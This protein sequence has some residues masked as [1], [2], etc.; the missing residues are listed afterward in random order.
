MRKIF[1]LLLAICWMTAGFSQKFRDASEL[2]VV[3][4]PF[5]CES[6]PFHRV[7]S[8]RYPRLLSGIKYRYACPA[9]MAIAFK[10]NSNVIKARW[11]TSPRNVGANMT[12]NAQK[13]LDLYIKQKGKW[14]FAGIAIPKKENHEYTLVGN[15]MSG[16]KECLL[17]LPVYDVLKSLEIGVDET[18]FLQ[19]LEPPFKHRI[20][21]YGSSIVHGVGVSR[22]GMTYPAL[23]SR[24]TGM[25]FINM[26]ISGM[27]KME[28]E[29]A[30]MLAD[31]EADAYILD[32][33]PNP[34][35]DQIRER[36]VPFVKYLRERR[37]GKPII[38]IQTIR[39]ETVNFDTKKEDLETAKMKAAR[40]EIA[41]LK[42]EGINDFFFI[43]EDEF[44]GSDHE[45]TVD[46]T[47]PS[48]LGFERMILKIEPRILKILKKY[49]IR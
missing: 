33:I 30:E 6:S 25:N 46:G 45:A 16:E 9:G 17:Y 34:S 44:I 38:F 12:A 4:A 27:A 28:P 24:R 22:A 21:V 1:L 40:E 2:T 14:I 39:R 20:A 7:D 48:D 19:P 8:L 35:P 43:D 10:T 29:V 41:K 3:G 11:Q 15:M 26:G 36:L 31:V 32:C 42:D 18:A 5:S 37:P 47:H 49:N 13:G 23:L